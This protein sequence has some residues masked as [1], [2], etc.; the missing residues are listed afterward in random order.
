[1][2][3]AVR[4]DMHKMKAFV[5]FRTVLDDS[6]KSNPEIGPLHVAWFE[7]EHH[8]VEAVAPFFARRF[9]PDALG[10]P[11]ARMQRR[12]ERRAIR[13]GPGGTAADAPPPDAGEQLWLTYYQHIFNPARLKMQMMQKEM[14]RKYWKNLPEA[15]LIYPL[16]A[17]ARQRSTRMVEQ[18]ATVPA[19]RIPSVMPIRLLRADG[20]RA[21]SPRGRPRGNARLNPAESAQ[22]PALWRWSVRTPR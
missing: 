4:R 18:A 20:R 16:A 19:R 11:D 21:A 2:A 12:M 9:A 8:I 13:F 1:M 15:E 6:F 3:Q 17:G 5:R 14:P 10:H 22:S 7:P